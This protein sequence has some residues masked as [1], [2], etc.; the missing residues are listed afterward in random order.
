MN[1]A[2]SYYKQI[3]WGRLLVWL[4]LIA[5]I[6]IVSFFVVFS[7]DEGHQVNRLLLSIC[8]GIFIIAAV[9]GDKIKN[10]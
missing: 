1:A 9:T 3:N 5:L 7:N 6:T 10:Q 4:A 8:S 2:Q